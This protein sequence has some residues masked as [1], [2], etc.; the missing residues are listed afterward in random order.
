MTI[1]AHYTLARD[2]FELDAEFSVPSHGI[3]A[4]FGPSGAGKTT[5]L[6]AIAGL[7]QPDSGVLSVRGQSWENVDKRLAAHE[8][9][10]G[11]VFQDSNLFPHLSVRRNL[12]FG[13]D[14]IAESERKIRLD[15]AI[16]WLGIGSLLDREPGGL[17]GG[18][19]QRVAIARAILTSPAL[20]LLDEPV[21]SLDAAGKDDILPYFE[22][23]HEQLEI[24]M[25]YVSHAADEVARLADQMILMEAG[26]VLATGPIQDLLTRFDLPLALSHDAESIIEANVAEHDEDFALTYVD[27]TG[28]RFSVMHKDLPVGRNVRLRILARDVSLTLERQS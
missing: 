16:A 11:Y 18:E 17:S 4:L 5:L 1:E 2:G 20:L 9:P 21:A 15:D 8:R 14:R 27:C 7:E 12:Q 23:L 10:I 28:G 13:Y 3:T 26:R 25:L 19:R 24:P 6:R 22:R